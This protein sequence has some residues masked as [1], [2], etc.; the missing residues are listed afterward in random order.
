MKVY[1]FIQKMSCTSTVEIR[2]LFYNPNTKTLENGPVFPA[3]KIPYIGEIIKNNPAMRAKLNS[4][5]I[6]NDHINI[7]CE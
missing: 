2:V 1:Q 4:F 7:F 3:S 6:N 5:S